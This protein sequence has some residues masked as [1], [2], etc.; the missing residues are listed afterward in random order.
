MEKL[1]ADEFEAIILF[2]DYTEIPKRFGF[3]VGWT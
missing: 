1:M 3:G 2:R